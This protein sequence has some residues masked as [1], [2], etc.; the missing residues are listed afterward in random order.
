MRK[1][2]H[3]SVRVQGDILDL[4]LAKVSELA[5]GRWRRDPAGEEAAGD[6]V[7][8][9]G[10][11]Y[12]YYVRV[13]E[14]QTEVV[15]LYKDDELTLNNIFTGGD[16]ITHAAHGRIAADLWNAGMK[17]ACKELGLAGEFTPS[18][19][20][21]PEAGLP[22]DVLDALNYFGGGANKS[23]GSG[24]PSD[25]ESWCRFL[26]LL[27]T[28]GTEMDESRLSA[29][30][31]EKKFPEAV[32]TDLLKEHE[33]AMALLPLYDQIREEKTDPTVQ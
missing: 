8:S 22:P 15:F 23:T 33:L 11:S 28:T 12:I 5:A 13:D 1:Y 17:L 26:A 31:T 6:I 25:M 19:D 10:I 27:H 18:R 4:F 29:Y 16:P 14:P 2:S 9:L 30:L 3:I 20:V 7:E 21:R 32:V 24:H